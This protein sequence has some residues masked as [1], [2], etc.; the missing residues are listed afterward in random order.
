LAALKCRHCGNIVLVSIWADFFRFHEGRC[1]RCG[2]S[3][4]EEVPATFVCLKCKHR[5]Q[6]PEGADRYLIGDCPNCLSKEIVLSEV[7]E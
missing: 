7:M 4:W 6:V 1:V 3:N 5:F 2:V